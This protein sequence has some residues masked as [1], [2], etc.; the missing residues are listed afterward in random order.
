MRDRDKT[1]E[2][3]IREL[4]ETRQRYEKFK[5]Q[6]Q[7]DAGAEHEVDRS[8]PESEVRREASE[9]QAIFHALPDLYFQLDSQGTILD[10]RAGR[11][12]DLYFPYEMLAGKRIQ[13]VHARV[14]KQFEQAILQV[15]GTKTLSVIEYSIVR[16]PEE[17][18]YEAR[19]VPF[20]KDQIIV[21]V[22]NIT[23]R[24]QAEEQLKFLSLHD[25]LTR[26]YNR[27]Y[28]E[29]EMRR[30]EGGRAYPVGIIVCDVDGLK[31][32]ND[33]L[34][35]NTGDVMLI[36]AA[37]VIKNTL[38]QVEMVARIGGDEFAVILP[39]N[40]RQVLEGVCDR[41][42]D[43]VN[44]YNA[45]DPVLPLSISIGCSVCSGP[46]GGMEDAFKK[47]DNNMYREKLYRSRT[48]SSAIVGTLMNTL[49]ARGITTEDQTTRIHELVSRLAIAIGLGRQ[50]MI[51]L[52]LLVRFHD[53]GRIGIPSHIHYKSGPL[54]P[55]EIAEMRRHSEIGHRIAQSSP[56]LAPIA[57]CILK[58]HEWFDGSG[59]PLSLKGDEIPL[60]C[61]IM[62]IAYAYD[63]MTNDR[64]YRKA[65]TSEQAFA[66]LERGAGTQF[67]PVLVAE[68]LRL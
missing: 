39:V 42:R 37:N 12:S 51:D 16:L 68:F 20:G 26:L 60:E 23:E 55:E 66:E 19:L 2:Q 35:H 65:M 25:P 49:Q 57:D 6:C 32:I 10:L 62:A 41:I 8:R 11:A 13:D 40:D 31:L 29:Q 53:I 5:A 3:L 21:V 22:R 58:H 34:G 52:G 44:S 67:D 7:S 61:R 46:P 4:T 50:S 56:E 64:P 48:A 43:A 1:K 54:N 15:L 59:Y 18:S 36:E 45:A 38:R 17:Q 28:F 63:A 30:F 27:A 24:K 9:L 14:G 33:T 47:A